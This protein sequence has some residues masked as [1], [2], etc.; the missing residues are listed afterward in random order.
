MAVK[1]TEE[2][3]GAER[4]WAEKEQ[5]RGKEERGD[6]D[7]WWERERD[8]GLEAISTTALRCAGSRAAWPTLDD[9]ALFFERKSWRTRWRP[10]EAWLSTRRR[11]PR[12][13]PSWS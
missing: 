3:S 2:I 13:R 12:R 9:R 10:A 8:Y 4:K 7:K 6:K 5:S 1:K 11:T